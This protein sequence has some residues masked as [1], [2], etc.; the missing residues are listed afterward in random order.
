[1]AGNKKARKNV[2][3]N[4]TPED[5][6]TILRI[7]SG[8]KQIARKIEKTVRERLSAVDAGEVASD[9]FLALDGVEDEDVWERSGRTEFGYMDP[10][11]AASEIFEEILEPFL[12]EAK[13]LQKLS[14]HEE[15]KKYFMGIAKGMYRFEQESCSGLAEYVEGEIQESFAYAFGEWKKGQK[16]KK[17]AAEVEAF[18]RENFPKWDK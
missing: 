5:S 2:L 11:E 18:A 4:I 6:L 13:K 12:E 10:G 7:L 9:V 1:M 15:A 3:E 17:D 16:S 8:D 14:M